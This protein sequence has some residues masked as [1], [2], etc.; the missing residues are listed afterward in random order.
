MPRAPFQVL[1]FPYRRRA[2]GVIEYALFR[3]VDLGVWQ[4]I[5]GRGEDQESPALA[6]ARE[7]FEE[8]GIDHGRPFCRLASVGA[9]PVEHFAGRAAW[10]TA[11]QT[12]PEYSFGVDVASEPIHLSRE[13]S[14]VQWLE[15]GEAYALLEWK[16]NRTAL[17]E[18]D[19]YL[20][21]GPSELEVP[22]V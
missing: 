6:A 12:I 5:A 17:C 3:R 20:R 8:A 21:T 2:D 13:H 7:A 9:V 16:S 15:F 11:L 18:L 22:A 10:D 14:T 19:A 4:G 1:V